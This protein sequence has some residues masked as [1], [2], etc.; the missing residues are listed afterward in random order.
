[1]ASLSRTAIESMGF[2]PLSEPASIAARFH[3]LHVYEI[4][5]FLVDDASLPAQA[6]AVAGRPYQLAV[7]GS[8]NAVC[9]TLIDDDLADSEEEWQKEHKC[10]PPYLLTPA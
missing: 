5:G 9:R 4:Q 6:G 10:T 8:V 1:M 3:A 7:G 2:R